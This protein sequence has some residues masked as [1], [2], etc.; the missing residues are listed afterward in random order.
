[1]LTG[2]VAMLVVLLVAAL[3]PAIGLVIHGYAA[4]AW[5][6]TACFG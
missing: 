1:M 3:L 5:S 2:R 6:T 4:G